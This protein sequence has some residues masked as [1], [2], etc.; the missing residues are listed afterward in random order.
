MQGVGLGVLGMSRGTHEGTPGYKV[1]PQHT[2]V[3]CSRADCC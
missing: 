2:V 1:E 3:H